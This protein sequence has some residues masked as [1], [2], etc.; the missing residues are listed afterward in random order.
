MT[1]L[2]GFY[3]CKVKTNEGYLGLLPVHKDGL[4]MPNGEWY[5]WYFSE[6][7]KFARDNGYE[8]KVYKGYSF[9]KV[10]K[11]FDKYVDDLFEKKKL[12]PLDLKNL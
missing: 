7:L 11:A 10:Y 8:I 2:F 5:G 3:F 4:T 9:N 1:D 12:S 6:E